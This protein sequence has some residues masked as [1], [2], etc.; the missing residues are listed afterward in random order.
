MYF[1]RHLNR[2]RE[3]DEKLNGV[4]VPGLLS[5]D[6]TNMGGDAIILAEDDGVEDGEGDS[7]DEDTT[8]KKGK[9]RKHRDVN[10]QPSSSSTTS[11]KKKK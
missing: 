5:E 11:K 2:K 8:M 9:K 10:R 4:C 3:E 6:Y 1:D 7:Q